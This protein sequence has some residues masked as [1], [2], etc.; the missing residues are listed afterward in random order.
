MFNPP[1]LN[2]NLPIQL[3]TYYNQVSSPNFHE[4]A[5]GILVSKS[6]WQ[7]FQ[8]LILLVIYN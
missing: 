5:N 2:R 7:L 4:K 6:N 1:C 3:L 8:F